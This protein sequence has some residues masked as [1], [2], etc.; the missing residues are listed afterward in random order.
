MFPSFL[1]DEVPFSSACSY[2]QC[3]LD[4]NGQE[5]RASFSTPFHPF[6]HFTH[7]KKNSLNVSSES[8]AKRQTV[9]LR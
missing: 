1:W 7:G 5:K 3:K 9:L 8:T 4:A 2:R 6:P